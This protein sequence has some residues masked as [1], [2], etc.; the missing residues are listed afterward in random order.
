DR[1]PRGGA[2]AR[3]GV[4]RVCA[5]PRQRP[6]ASAPPPRAP[7]HALARGRDDRLAT[8]GGEVYPPRG[9]AEEDAPPPPARGPDDRLATAGA[10]VDPLAVVAEEGLARATDG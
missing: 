5:C 6:R 2:G 10:E 9:V 8:A 4:G 1:L 3:T 7:P